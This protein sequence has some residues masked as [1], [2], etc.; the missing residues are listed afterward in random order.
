MMY[1]RV[2]INS[3]AEMAMLDKGATHNFMVDREIQN[4]GLTLAQHSSRI[5]VVN[6]EA[7]PI[8]GVACVE[9]KVSAWTGKCNLM[10]VPLDDFDVILGMDFLR[11]ANAMVK[12]GLRHGE[13]TYLA[14]LI[15]IKPDVVQDVPDEVAELLQ[16]FKDVFLLNCLRSC[17]HD[18]F[19][20]LTKAKYYTKIDLRSGYWQVRV[21][22]GDEPKT[23]C[24]TRWFIKGYSKIVNPLKDLLRKDQNWEQTI[25]CNDAISGS[26]PQN[27]L[28]GKSFWENS[29]L[30][31]CTGQASTM[32]WPMLQAE[33]W[34]RGLECLI[35][36]Y[37]LDSG[38]LYAKGGRV[39]VPTGTMRR[40]L[41]R[42]THDPQWAGHPGIDRMVT[43]L[44]HRYYWLRMEEDVESYVRTCLV[45]QLDKVERK[46]EA[47]LLQP[48]PI[49]EVPWQSISMDFISGFP[50]VNG[51]ASV[52]FVVDRFS[53]YG[54]FIAAPHTCL[55]E[56]ATE[57]FFKNV[58]KYFGVPKD[59]VSD[60]MPGLPKGNNQRCPHEISVQKM[61][62]K[63][64]AA[65]RFARSKQE[66]LDEAKHSLAKAQC[67]L[68]KYA[69]MGRSKSVHRGLIPKYDG[70]FEDLLD[71]V[72]EQTQCAPP[73][74][75][76]EFEKSVLKILDHR[77]M[78][79]SKKNRQTDYLVHCS[80]ESEADATW[81]WDV[82][83][84]QFEEKLDEYWVVREGVTPSTRALGS[85]G[86]GDRRSIGLPSS[87]LRG[88]ACCAQRRDGL[89][90]ACAEL[91]S[92][93][94]HSAAVCEGRH[95]AHSGRTGLV[96]VRAELNS[97][98]QHPVAVRWSSTAVQGLAEGDYTQAV[99]DSF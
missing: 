26:C 81:E 70:H 27:K 23:T 64:P 80:G 6:S 87:S 90:D 38:L 94:P 4:F 39:F 76:K 84:W 12:A 2:Q 14:A 17:P 24:V 5:K 30:S 13:Q 82:T 16:E 21:A 89:A 40:R 58:T 71:T 85:F 65:Y 1:V 18:L 92:M 75:R 93:A 96:D 25:A 60:R 42:E 61:G 69:D 79:Q 53:K 83:L 15:E 44:A 97:V 57:L 32:T 55:A 74:I 91:D 99:T 86:W 52:L 33:N 98:A 43:L 20:K 50:K 7:K 36:K 67:R 34:L 49:P 88:Q 73:M 66:Q 35:R 22:R 54:I 37:W 78:G 28:V 47:G 3:K 51:M 29:T 46:K 31:G 41:L 68:K 62:G 45:C 77:T 19:D 95:A 10:V 48:L 72:R 8:Q 63:C 56:T 59:I 11:L 9:L